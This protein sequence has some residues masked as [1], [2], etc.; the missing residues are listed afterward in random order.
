M[1]NKDKAVFKIDTAD[2]LQDVEEMCYDTRE[3]GLFTAEQ[4]LRVLENGYGGAM[5][6]PGVGNFGVSHIKANNEWLRKELTK[7]KY[8]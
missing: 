4:A 1:K 5:F 6:A 2:N 8:L 3:R 7:K